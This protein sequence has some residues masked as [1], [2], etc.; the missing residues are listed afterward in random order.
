[1]STTRHD[2][3]RRI[4]AMRANPVF[5]GC[6]R[7]ELAEIDGL[8]AGI[9]VA[10]G[11]TLIREGS[12]GRECFVTLGGTAVVSRAGEPVGEIGPG[13]IVGEMA[14]LGD[15]PRNAT[16]VAATP[17]QLLVLDGREFASLL[18]IAPSAAAALDRLVASRRSGSG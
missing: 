3:N 1:M 4:A 16:V 8:G 2:T 9:E 18:A 15:S 14:L 10:A 7:R 17:M 6:S 11:R 5:A 12:T 13:S